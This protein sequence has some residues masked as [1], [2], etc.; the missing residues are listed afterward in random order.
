MDTLKDSLTIRRL[1]KE[2]ES[3]ANLKVNY[4]TFVQRYPK[5]FEMICNENCSDFILNHMIQT[6]ISVQNG[7]RTQEEGSIKMGEVLAQE[8]I[9]EEILKDE[10]R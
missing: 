5:L 9:P 7:V 8:Y 2:G 10:K 3:E 4:P 6:H 1:Y